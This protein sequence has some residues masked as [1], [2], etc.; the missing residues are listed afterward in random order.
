MLERARASFLL[1]QCI[2]RGTFGGELLC[3]GT[4]RA[5]Y[6]NADTLKAARL[7]DTLFKDSQT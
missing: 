1:E 2:Y 7:P 5:A 3:Q 4:T 6:I